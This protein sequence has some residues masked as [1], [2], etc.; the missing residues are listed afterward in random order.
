MA[1]RPHLDE[2]CPRDAATGLRR[3]VIDV[4]TTPEAGL[5]ESRDVQPMNCSLGSAGRE[6]R[7]ASVAHIFPQVLG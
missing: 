1:D 7:R 4:R 6:P 2:N 5:P 3:R